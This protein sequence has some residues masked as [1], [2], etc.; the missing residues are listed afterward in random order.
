VVSGNPFFTRARW[1][2]YHLLE[3]L[4][5]LSGPAKVYMTTFSFSEESLRAFYKLKKTGLITELSVLANVAVRRYKAD[6]M[7]FAERVIDDLYMGNY[8]LKI[9][10]IQSDSVRYAVNQSANATRNPAHEAG[11]IVTDE[12]AQPYFDELKEL[13]L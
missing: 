3:Y 11:I 4:L 5:T 2:S 7:H 8:H 1:S 12:A 6:L 9:T 13:M 10:A